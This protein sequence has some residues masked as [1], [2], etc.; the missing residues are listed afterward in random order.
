MSSDGAFG[1]LCVPSLV[2][3]W[4]GIVA[5]FQDRCLIPLLS[6]EPMSH[7][8]PNGNG[9]NFLEA[10]SLLSPCAISHLTHGSF[11]R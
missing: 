10:T 5:S 3:G 8:N 1:A 9:E 11:S 7:L 2:A 4:S 6:W